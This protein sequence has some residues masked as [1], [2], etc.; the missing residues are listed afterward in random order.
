M[1][2][3]APMNWMFLYMLFTIILMLLTINNYF[4]YMYKP[5]T[6]L[7]TKKTKMINWKW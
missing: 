6:N 3:M 1:P 5:K 2:Q 7:I 4:F